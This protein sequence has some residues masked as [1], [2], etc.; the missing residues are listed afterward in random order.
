M[1]LTPQLAKSQRSKYRFHSYMVDAEGG[2]IPRWGAQKV[3]IADKMD[4]P[5]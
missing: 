3:G 1:R 4:S 2:A 5:G